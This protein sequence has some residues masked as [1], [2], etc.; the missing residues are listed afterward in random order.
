MKAL[1]SALLTLALLF[2]L[3]AAEQVVTLG[4]SLTFAYEAEF[5]F[6][7]TITGVGTIGDNMPQTV[8]NWIEILDGSGFRSEWFDLG[9][10]DSITV[11]PPFDPPFV[12]YFRQS[13]NWAI[14][15]L[16]VDGLRQFVAGEAS[17]LDLL[18]DDPEF[19]TIDQIV[20]YS[21]YQEADF[22]LADMESQISSSAERVVIAIGG[23]DIRSVYGIIYEGGSAG[24]FADDFIADLTYVIDRVRTLKPGIQIVVANVPHVGITNKVRRQFPY[25]VEKTGRV[26]VV[27]RELNGRIAALAASRGIGCADLYSPTIRMI[28]PDSDLCVQ[29]I[30]LTN[31]TNSVGG[32]GAAWLNG[33]LSDGFHP[34][35]IAQSV[36]ANEIMHAFNARYGTGIPLLSAKEILG[37]IWGR[38]AAQQDMPFANWM[39]RNGLEG[40]SADDDSDGDGL[41]TGVEFAAGLDPGRRDA[42]RILTTVSGGNLG[43]AFPSRLVTSA[44][45][46]LAAETSANLLA[47]F[48]PVA[49]LAG[50]DGL[51]HASIPVG[52]VPGFL[53]LNAVVTT[54]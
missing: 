25:D 23:N 44:N 40:L 32:L 45:Y 28:D 43:L 10:R 26:S 14:P 12:L 38:S 22:A 35:T 8:R 2:P 41:S 17:F 51:L 3:Q 1:P 21:D 13:G 49:A 54:P 33:P 30:V 20:N 48:T 19:T 39:I 34:N 42:D 36:I 31:T 37:D 29:G 18:D 6:Q 53:R 11:D 52:P 5:C 27:L 50:S 46:T 24:T 9:T 15:G 16:K 4:D 47:P 7:Q